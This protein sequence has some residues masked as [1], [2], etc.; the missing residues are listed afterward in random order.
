MLE[1]CVQLTASNKQWISDWNFWFLNLI[2]IPPSQNYSNI[3]LDKNEPLEIHSSVLFFCHSLSGK[4][5]CQVRRDLSFM[6]SWFCH[7]VGVIS[8]FLSSSLFTCQFR[9]FSALSPGECPHQLYP[10]T[11]RPKVNL[12]LFMSKI[13]FFCPDGIERH[14]SHFLI[15]QVLQT[16]DVIN[17]DVVTVMKF[18]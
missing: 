9:S 2:P 7:Q 6:A 10:A 3:S 16:V 5:W 18:H 14:F 11:Y 4:F 17:C 12:W 15:I 1:W 8:H 13:R